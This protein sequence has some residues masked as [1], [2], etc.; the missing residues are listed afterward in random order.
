MAIRPFGIAMLSI[1]TLILGALLLLGGLMVVIASSMVATMPKVAEEVAKALAELP[2]M[3][4]PVHSMIV[5]GTVLAIIGG[6]ILVMGVIT[7]LVGWGLWTGRNW[8]RWIAIVVFGLGALSNLGNL[9]Q[10]KFGSIISLV[11]N[12]L[13]VY[14]LFTPHVKGFFKATV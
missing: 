14:Y 6:V 10:G 8:A 5:I 2:G 7:L 11:I 4:I 3:P 13:I 12:G 9:L 1:L